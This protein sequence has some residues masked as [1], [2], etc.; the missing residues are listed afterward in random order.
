[1]RCL[2]RLCSG[3]MFTWAINTDWTQPWSPHF[4]HPTYGHILEI[5]PLTRLA[6]CSPLSVSA[7]PALMG[8]FIMSC[9]QTRLPAEITAPFQSILD[10]V[11]KSV[12]IKCKFEYII[13][14]VSWGCSNKLPQTGWLKIAE[15]YCLTVLETESLRS[16]YHIVSSS[17]GLW[18]RICSRLLCVI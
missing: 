10:I 6:V 8:T 5:L 16:R 7:L 3:H 11:G 12:F 1:M 14:L 13:A 9:L 15:I 2:T 17:W 4:P 18:S